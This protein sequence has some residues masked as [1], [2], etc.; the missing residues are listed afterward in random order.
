MY[1]SS[2]LDMATTCCLLDR[3]PAHEALAEEEED[4]ARALASVDVAG[5]VSR[6]SSS[7]PAPSSVAA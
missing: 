6:W 7:Q 5:V 2:Q 3:L 4:P 1:S